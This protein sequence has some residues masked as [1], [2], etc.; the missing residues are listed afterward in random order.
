MGSKRTKINVAETDWMEMKKAWE[1]WRSEE[2][3]H[4]IRLCNWKK[5]A[6]S[7]RNGKVLGTDHI[8]LWTDSY[9]CPNEMSRSQLGSQV[10]SQ[11]VGTGWIYKCGSF[12]VLKTFQVSRSGLSREG[13]RSKFWARGLSLFRSLGGRSNRMIREEEES[14]ESEAL[15]QPREENKLRGKWASRWNAVDRLILSS[16]YYMN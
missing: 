12:Q 9:C 8:W 7:Y 11:Q 3:H 5:G 13:K 1:Q 2:C 16:H 10:L 15:W 6:S 14:Q 4:N